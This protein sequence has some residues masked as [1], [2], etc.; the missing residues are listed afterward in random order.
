MEPKVYAPL[1]ANA[2]Q[3]QLRMVVIVRGISC[4]TAE[5]SEMLVPIANA[6]PLVASAASAACA[7][8]K[9]T[10][11]PIYFQPPFW[12]AV[13]GLCA[14]V[15]AYAVA[16][17]SIRNKQLDFILYDHKQF[18]E[19]QKKRCELLVE[20][21]RIKAGESGS[22]KSER[23]TIEAKMFY[24]RFWSL[25][26]DGFV[27]WSDGY[28]PT[29]LFIYWLFSRW[30]EF[31][32]PSEDWAFETQTMQTS[33]ADVTKRWHRSPDERSKQSQQ[34]NKF[35][36][37]MNALQMSQTTDIKALLATY[38]PPWWKR[39]FRKFFGAY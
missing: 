38:G 26:F 22:W 3:L 15:V 14:L 29:S 7:A 27:A 28:L 36:G 34:V 20:K 1:C 32:E 2:N 10:N 31:K 9:A 18:D 24:D 19:L 13:I 39:K 35:M 23:L 33:F 5:K 6:Q 8:D 30:R 4:R 21:A 16:R 37:L 25:Q 11:A 12:S 17:F